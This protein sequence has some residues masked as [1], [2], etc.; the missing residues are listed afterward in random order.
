M[1]YTIAVCT[2]LDSYGQWDC[3]KHVEFNS[4]NK[5]ETLVNLSRFSIRIYHDARS[6]ERQ[7]TFQNF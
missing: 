5:L 4:K 1:K 2:V 6:L 7:N 3:P